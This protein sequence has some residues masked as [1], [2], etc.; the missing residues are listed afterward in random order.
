MTAGEIWFVTHAEVVQDPAVPVPRWPLSDT[1][2]RRHRAFNPVLAAAGVTSIWASDEQKAQDAAAIHAEALQ[3]PIRTEAA[4]GEN[5]RSATGYLPPAEFETTADAFFAHPDTSIRGWE[6]AADA[7][8]RIVAAVRDIAQGA[9]PGTA[10]VVAHGG[11]GALLMAHGR[12]V[13]ISRAL[14]Q[15]GGGGGNLFRLSRSDLSALTDW[16]PIDAP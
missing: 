9:P 14:D 13:P 15:T 4:L 5:D 7:Q 10:L 6:R 1:G 2:R 11:V 3:L 8:H 12:G 16:R